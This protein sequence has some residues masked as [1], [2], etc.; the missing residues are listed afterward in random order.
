MTNK[1]FQYL[2]GGLTV[3]ATDTLYKK[4]VLS[5][6]PKVG[7]LITS[8]NPVAL[9][10]ALESLVQDYHKLNLGK[11]DTLNIFKEK[12]CWEHQVAILLNQAK[13]TFK[14]NFLINIKNANFTYC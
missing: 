7:S 11:N 8:N 9:A 1:L 4:E 3:V 14:V 5:Q 6:D 2:H 13:K 12:L 10:N